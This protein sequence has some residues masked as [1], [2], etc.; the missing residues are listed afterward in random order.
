M[1][2]WACRW[3]VA[4]SDAA[5]A[6]VAAVDAAASAGSQLALFRNIAKQGTGRKEGSAAQN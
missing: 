2:L 4:A 3:Q 5:V 1:G 6:V